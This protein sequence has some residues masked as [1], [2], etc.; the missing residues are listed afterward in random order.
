VLTQ[1]SVTGLHGR[2]GTPLPAIGRG[3]ARPQGLRSKT[4]PVT[5]I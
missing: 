5:R 4:V 1:T 3:M 2:D